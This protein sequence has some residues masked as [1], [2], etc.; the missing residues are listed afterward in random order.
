MSQVFVDYCSSNCVGYTLDAELSGYSCS[1]CGG[2]YKCDGCKDGYACPSCPEGATCGGSNSCR[3]ITSCGSYRTAS[4]SS[5]VCSAGYGTANG[6]CAS[7]VTVNG[8]NTGS[9]SCW[10]APTCNA[11]YTASGCYCV[12]ADEDLMCN[13]DGN[14]E[15]YCEY[16]CENYPDQDEC[17][18]SASGCEFY[19]GNC[20]TCNFDTSSVC[21]DTNCMRWCSNSCFNSNIA[22]TGCSTYKSNCKFDLSKQVCQGCGYY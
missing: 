12:K 11:G 1:S 3:K 2:K 15:K 8:S 20:S 14:C 4:G 5:C 9:G 22:G 13:Y 18:G 7:Q 10:S 6:G 21:N 16:D 17:Q 19:V